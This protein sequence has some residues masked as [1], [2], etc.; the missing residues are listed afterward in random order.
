[1]AAKLDI[2]TKDKLQIL[3]LQDFRCATYTKLDFTSS[4]I[5]LM[6]MGL[7][8]VRFINTYAV[9]LFRLVVEP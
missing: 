7:G 8:Q 1:M 5:F 9:G 4:D 6:N 2:K 3:H